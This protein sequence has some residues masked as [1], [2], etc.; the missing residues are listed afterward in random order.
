MLDEGGDEGGM[1]VGT[2]TAGHPR[3]LMWDTAAP[4]AA[5]WRQRR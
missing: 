2:T 1:V 5:S 3:E 4:Y